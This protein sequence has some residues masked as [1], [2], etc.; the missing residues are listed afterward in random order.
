MITTVVWK[1]SLHLTW[2]TPSW[3]SSLQSVLCLVSK[4]PHLT[5]IQTLIS[6]MT[7]LTQRSLGYQHW[8][9]NCHMP[10][11]YQCMAFSRRDSFTLGKGITVTSDRVTSL[12]PLV[13]F[14]CQGHGVVG[15][16]FSNEGG[17]GAHRSTKTSEQQR[18]KE[19]GHQRGQPRVENVISGSK[20]PAKRRTG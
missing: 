8:C 10:W 19:Q 1:R 6:Q 18:A 20:F 16:V 7:C 12:W 13:V 5:H 3:T 9:L 14:V 2:W 15:I 11:E 17:N 4:L